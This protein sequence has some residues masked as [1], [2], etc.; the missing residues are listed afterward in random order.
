MKKRGVSL[1]SLSIAI[2]IMIVLISIISVSLMYSVN[3]A[4]KMT[5]AKEIYNIQSIVTE[6][7]NREKMLPSVSEVITITPTDTTQ[8]EGETFIDGNLSLNVL[9]LTELDIKNTNYGNKTLGSTDNEKAK[10]IY[11]V[12]EITG[13]VYYIAGFESDGKV[14]YT[15]TDELRKMI[16]KDQNITIGESTVIFTPSKIGWSN[17]GV[18]VSVF[19]P[20]EFTSPSITLSN[21]NITYTTT[22]D[23]DGIYYTVNSAKVAEEYTITV[24]YT[25]NGIAS[26]ASYQTRL[27]LVA[28]AIS[29]DE[30]IINTSDTIKGL[31]ATD[32][33]SGI[34]YFK[35][36]QGVIDIANAKEYIT[37]YGKNIN[38]G[39]IYFKNKRPYTIYAEDKAG[40]YCILYVDED[41]NL[42]DVKPIDYGY[43]IIPEG[44]TVSSISGETK[45]SEGLVIYEGTDVVTDVDSDENGIIDAQETRNQYVWIP[46]IDMDNFKLHSEYSSDDGYERTLDTDFLS[47]SDTIEYYSDEIQQYK[48]M[49]ESVAKYGGF[50]IARYEAGLPD[51]VT[52]TTANYGQMTD[53]TALTIPVSRKNANVWN[54]I[55]FDESKGSYYLYFDVGEYMYYGSDTLPG[56]AKVAKNAYKSDTVT[57]HLIYGEQYD[58]A[59]SFIKDTYPDYPDYNDG[60]YRDNYESGNVEHKTGIDLDANTSKRAKNVYDLSGNVFDWSYVAALQVI[61]DDTY[62]TWRLCV[63][64]SAYCYSPDTLLWPYQIG[65]VSEYIGFRVVL[66]LE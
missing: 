56:C 35:Y 43:P 21:T 50:Y 6:Y 17:V 48:K 29:K 53:G 42:T 60:W 19:V 41:G 25:K 32:N 66:C 14:Y 3:N 44:F 52:T 24:S 61:D 38:G 22:S 45:V 36:V 62:C 11:A 27:D 55:P 31:V 40:N 23:D 20:S 5:F 16:E 4:K 39:S 33:G 30:S 26:S 47:V 18:S 2:V 8:F 46:V 65:C 49:K 1:I 28:P 63:G 34:R 7:I 13:R 54:R 37:A 58:A 59:I 9:N 15:L 10:D 12:S 57:S 51:G 64:G